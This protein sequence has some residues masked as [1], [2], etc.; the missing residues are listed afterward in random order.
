ME[1]W[2]ET[3]AASVNNRIRRFGGQKRLRT[4]VDTWKESL[5]RVSFISSGNLEWD[6][7]LNARIRERRREKSS[8]DRGKGSG[9]GMWLEQG[10]QCNDGEEG[11]RCEGLSSNRKEGC[12]FFQH[13]NK[14]KRGCGKMEVSRWRRAMLSLKCV[15]HLL[16]CFIL[17]SFIYPVSVYCILLRATHSAVSQVFTKKRQSC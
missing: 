14:E 6:K 2:G 15:H 4:S 12:F 17:V 10:C 9:W 8:E 7:N 13:R 16:S 1:G 3:Q 11:H 5:V